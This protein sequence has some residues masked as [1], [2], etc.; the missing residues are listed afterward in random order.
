[1]SE[2]HVARLGRA[3]HRIAEAGA[4][5]ALITSP[6]NVRY[7]SGLVSSNA[8]VLLP[9]EGLAVLGTDSRYA[10]TA[11]RNCPDVELIIERQIEPAL[12]RLAAARGCRT[13]AFEAQEMTV[14]RHSELSA[15]DGGPEL[16][17]LG[18]VVEQLRMVKDETEIGRASC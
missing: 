1:M 14:E 16:V 4:D 15:L 6:A 17:P 5:A 12:A 11:E 8:A 7:L 13:L 9:A 3:Q 18:R 10:E 2:V